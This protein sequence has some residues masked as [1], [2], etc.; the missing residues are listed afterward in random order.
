MSQSD[1]NNPYRQE[2]AFAPNS[3]GVMP[4]AA[5][6]EEWD[7]AAFV[8]R[9]Y[10]HLAGAVGAFVGIEALI[11]TLV[12]A[13]ALHNLVGTMVSG[14]NWL[15]VLGAMMAVSWVAQSWASSSASQG[16]Q[17]LG[18][19]LYV[20]AEA[21]IFVPLLYLA[22]RYGGP[23]TIPTAG[24]LTGIVFGGLT[25]VVFITRADLSGLGKY[26]WLG[27]FLALGFIVCSIFFSFQLGMLFNVAMIGLAGGY[28]LYHTSNIMLHYRLDQHVAA[29]LALFAAVATLFWYIL[30]FVME[31]NRR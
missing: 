22:S 28:I 6:A 3:G 19:A 11:F 16:M 8:R 17:Y 1:R 26:L 9:T 7:R 20:V 12:P 29:S 10:A 24:I 21:V 23:A 15:F 2:Y 14:W 27:G 13:A 18:L 30:R 4:V 5:M 31:M 25:G